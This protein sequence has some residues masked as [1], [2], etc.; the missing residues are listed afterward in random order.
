MITGGMVFQILAQ[1]NNTF[2][3]MHNNSV[4]NAQLGSRNEGKKPT[5]STTIPLLLLR[6]SEQKIVFRLRFCFIP[7]AVLILEGQ[8]WQEKA[9]RDCMKS[10]RN[11]ARGCIVDSFAQQME[12]KNELRKLI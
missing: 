10:N 3:L 9:V 5:P 2:W 7:G 4:K 6:T 11:S 8:A 1:D 12:I